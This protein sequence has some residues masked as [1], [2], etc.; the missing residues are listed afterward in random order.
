MS[1]LT[2]THRATRRNLATQPFPGNKPR[3]KKLRGNIALTPDEIEL[4]MSMARADR[5]KND[6]R[7]Y[8][9]RKRAA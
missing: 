5:I 9:A 1:E 2:G 4:A 7:N 3:P 6:I 8:A